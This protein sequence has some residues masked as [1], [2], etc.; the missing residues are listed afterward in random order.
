M[1]RERWGEILKGEHEIK[2]SA[3]RQEDR[4]KERG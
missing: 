1:H 2:R 4:Q 3:K